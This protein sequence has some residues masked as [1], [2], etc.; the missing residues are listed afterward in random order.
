MR[1]IADLHTHSRFAR[2]CSSRITPSSMEETALVKGIN[3]VSTGDFTHPEWLN[4]VKAK[5][6][7]DGTGLFRLKGSSKGVRFILGT[8]ICT[9]FTLAG[10]A[11]KIHT[12]VLLPSTESAEAV[13]DR[14]SKHGSLASD[15]RPILSMKAAELLDIVFSSEKNAF[16]FPAHAWTPYFGVFGSM[17]GFDSMK[18]AYEDQERNIHALE[19]GLSSDP[20]MNWRVSA[21]DRYT[22]LSNSDMHS[23]EKMGREANVFEVDEGKFTYNEIVRAM[24]EKDGGAL[25]SNLKFYP[26]EGKYHY[27]GHRECGFSVNPET[28]QIMIC[29]VCGRKLVTGVLHRVNDLADRQLG[30][31][32]QNAVPFVKLVPLR[33]VIA[34]ATRK[35]VYSAAVENMYKELTTNLGTEFDVL[36]RANE[37]DIAKRSTEE[38][39]KAIMNM[40]S[41]SIT[42]KPG[43]AGVFGEID[44]LNRTK[45][46]LE[47]VKQR[48]LFGTFDG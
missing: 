44:L 28:S 7:G 48:P 37:E 46:R 21:L 1:V 13:N 32:R 15:G 5:L 31:K 26:E 47:M 22:L 25:K 42:I 9:V 11:R 35:T 3:L 6:E 16:V 38:V 4:E 36:M 27:D 30:Y 23:L 20:P 2:A 34:N 17:S 24:K 19:M 29:P 14:L 8:E 43:Y 12:C 45:G 33:E 41:G 40:R 18:E 39:G 10:R